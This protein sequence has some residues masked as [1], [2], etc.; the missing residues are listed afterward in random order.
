MTACQFAE[1]APFSQDSALAD[2]LWHLSEK[3]VGQEFK[4][5]A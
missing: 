3:L 1:C 4:L 5:D 2:K